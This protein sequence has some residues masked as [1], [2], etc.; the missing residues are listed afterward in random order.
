MPPDRDWWVKITDFG[1]SKRIDEGSSGKSTLKGTP[2][3][4]PPEMQKLFSGQR[5]IGA[6][7]PFAA[8]IWGVGQIAFLS[9]TKTQ[10]FSEPRELLQ[11][12]DKRKAFPLN[13]LESNGISKLG[14]DFMS[15]CMSPSPTERL[16]AVQARKH[17]WIRQ[18][19][20]K[21]SRSNS[22]RGSRYA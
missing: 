21:S 19:S 4:I 10:L 14:Q 17:Q 8:D 9:L 11:Y 3:Y 7:D 5:A 18:V 20:S 15:S 22:K 6:V 12:G 1:I 13:E 16:T 2:A